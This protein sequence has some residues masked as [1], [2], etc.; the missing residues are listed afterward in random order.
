MATA[1]Q[2]T[3]RHY[4]LNNLASQRILGT[5]LISDGDNVLTG[6]IVFHKPCRSK[7]VSSAGE[8]ALTECDQEPV[9]D[10]VLLCFH[11][12]HMFSVSS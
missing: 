3:R 6:L 10:D 5:G 11:N 12:S 2:Q 4:A 1:G 9:L 7:P 8:A